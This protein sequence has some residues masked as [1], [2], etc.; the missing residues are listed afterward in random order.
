MGRYEYGGLRL[1]YYDVVKSTCLQNLGLINVILVTWI[2]GKN[3]LLSAFRNMYRDLPW[4]WE[5]VRGLFMKMFSS[6]I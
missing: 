6:V 2:K 4:K 1:G 5:L 3:F